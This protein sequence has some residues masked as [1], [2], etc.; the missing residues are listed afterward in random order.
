MKLEDLV[1][2]LK[3][4]PAGR[5]P[6]L[7]G[8]FPAEKLAEVKKRELRRFREAQDKKWRHWLESVSR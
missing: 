3:G 1:Q 8:W 4:A 7:P 5:E 2:R 6:E